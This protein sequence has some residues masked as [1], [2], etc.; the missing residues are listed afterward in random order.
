MST[1][2]QRIR[3]EAKAL[4]RELYDEAPPASAEGCAMLEQMLS[5]LPEVPYTRLKSP[6]LRRGAGVSWPKT[7]RR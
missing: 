7:K 5:R 1:R 4:W 2:D 6:H 3:A